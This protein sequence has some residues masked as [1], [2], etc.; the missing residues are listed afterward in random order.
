MRVTP[1]TEAE[2]VRLYHAEGWKKGTIAAQLGVHH[3]T[4]ARI[5]AKNGLIPRPGLSRK[6]KVD[7]YVPFMIYT[8]EKFPKL[9]ASRLYQMVKE[10][11]YGGK[12]DHFRHIV[13]RL[14]PAPKAEA[15]LRLS[16]LPGEQAQVDWGHFGTLKVGETERKLVAFVM[17]LSYS[18]RIF[19]RFYFGEAT[20]NFLRGHVDAF[21]HFQS[22]PR[23]ILYD[24]LK[25]AVIERVDSA[26]RFNPELLKLSAHYRFSAKP[27]PPARPT[28]KGRV[29]RS[30]QY[31]RGAFFA[32]RKFN[33]L[34]DLNAQALKWCENEAEERK[35]FQE[36]SL[37]VAEAF[38]QERTSML[39]PPKVPYP[40]YDRLPVQ[41]G[42]TPYAR[43]DGN[44]YSVP[45]KFVRRTLLIEA[46]LEVVQII[47][48]IE[49]VAKHVRCFEKGKQIEAAE[50]IDGLV[51]EKHNAS[52]ARG[53]NRILN[54]A[55]SSKSFFKL[56][57]ER[58]HNMGRLTQLLI[59]ML[60]L[61]GAAEL[62]AALSETLIAGNIHSAAIQK[63]LERRRAARGLAP[64]VALKFL[65]SPRIDE[66]TVTPKSLSAYDRLLQSE[67][68]E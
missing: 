61:Y 54:V 24:N 41:I 32:A 8:L 35:C 25:S 5:L 26:I 34:T 55:P 20:A 16:T 62:E 43:F 68:L 7:A 29:E 65:K 59:S 64:P 6:S 14:R 3:S 53:M 13:S 40:V 21:E 37:T 10:R 31:I 18:R 46:T 27:V 15:F 57:A 42:K 66:V 23:E 67:D 50:H 49:V 48:G 12:P 45:H 52:R 4:V 19:L 38:R 56:A 36:K 9:N 17:V 11:G 1:E 63:T 2:I 47:D 28:S 60:E 44:D 51:K 22:V 58:G 39:P 30:I 33:D